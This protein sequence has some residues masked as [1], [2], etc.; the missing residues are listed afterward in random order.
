LARNYRNA[1]REKLAMFVSMSAPKDVE[2]NDEVIAR[3][4]REL[5]KEYPGN[6]EESLQRGSD[7]LVSLEGKAW[8]E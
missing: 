7:F 5:I 8:G 2:K 6:D 4:M 1:P 3:L